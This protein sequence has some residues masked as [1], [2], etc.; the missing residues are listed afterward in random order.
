MKLVNHD[1]VYR[2][3]DDQL[4][5]VVQ[6]LSAKGSVPP[7]PRD[8]RMEMFAVNSLIIT[9][10]T[11]LGRSRIGQKIIRYERHSAHAATTALCTDA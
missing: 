6:Y 8:Y 5:S 9:R 7:D 10:R 1:K 2:T 11:L 3:A 4:I